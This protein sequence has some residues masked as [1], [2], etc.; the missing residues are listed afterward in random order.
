MFIQL[1]EHLPRNAQSQPNTYYTFNLNGS[2]VNTYQFNAILASHLHC[3]WILFY[4][5]K[6]VQKI[7]FPWETIFSIFYHFKSLN[8]C[9]TQFFALRNCKK[10]LRLELNIHLLSVHCTVVHLFDLQLRFVVKAREYQINIHLMDIDKK[11]K[12]STKV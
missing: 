5:L 10:K 1:K 7:L 2:T 4:N 12:A 11:P 6:E 3:L 8:Q 9:K